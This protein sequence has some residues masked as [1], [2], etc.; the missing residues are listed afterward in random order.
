MP[1]ELDELVDKKVI[2]KVQVRPIQI[3]GF[4]GTYS[5]MK[6]TIDQ[7]VVEKYCGEFFE[8]QVVKF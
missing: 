1:K 7:T 5:V 3:R 2:F 4:E 6:L 8:S